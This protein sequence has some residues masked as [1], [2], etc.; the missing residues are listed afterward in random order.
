MP[1]MEQD[2]MSIRQEVC[3]LAAV[4]GTEISELARYQAAGAAGLVDQSRRP[5]GHP[6]Q[7]PP[8]MVER[9]LAARAEYGWGG[10][11]IHHYLTQQGHGPVPAPS[12][13][14]AILARHGVDATRLG[15][16]PL[17]WQRFEAPLPNDLWQIDFKG[18][19]PI[20]NG[21]VAP[22]LVLD[23]HSRFI[24][25]LQA[26][27][28]QQSASVQAQLTR[29]FQRY[30]L[31]ARLLGDNGGP[32]GSSHKGVGVP[33][34]RLTA[35]LI[36]LGI[37]VCHGRPYHP[38]TQGKIERCFRTL[39][40]EV[41]SRTAL[42]SAA[43]LQARFDA[44]RMVYNQLRP[45]EALGQHPPSSRYR[46]SP[47]PYPAELPPI[48]YEPS[49]LLARVSAQGFIR[50]ERK[51]YFISQAIPGDPVAVRPTAEPDIVAIWYGPQ[52][53]MLVD[54]RDPS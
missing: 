39:G 37:L 1:W 29:L 43:D 35:W 45:H 22:L 5:H 30:G 3:R 21:T 24:V 54:L 47:R 32:W 34:T 50:L 46:L 16:P 48:C 10:R 53:V 18:P 52:F 26:A 23:D 17:R 27:P 20:R 9:I 41:L 38:Q 15:D 6:W 31:P 11:K 2:R 33:L 4:P 42:T 8:E 44:W 12:T 49:D 7:T 40:A 19:V 36:R 28:N 13:I 25:G 51:R 14:T